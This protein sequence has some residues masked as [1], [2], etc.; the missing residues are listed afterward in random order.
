MDVKFDELPLDRQSILQCHQDP[1]VPRENVEAVCLFVH[2]GCA[3]CLR[4]CLL[5][6]PARFFAAHY[7]TS[8]QPHPNHSQI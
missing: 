1:D 8:D 6:G 5:A 3:P 4:S 7:V 2:L